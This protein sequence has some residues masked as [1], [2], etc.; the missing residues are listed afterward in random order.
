MPA[1]K[2][3]TAPLVSLAE[4]QAYYGTDTTHTWTFA[5]DTDAVK[6]ALNAPA[7]EIVET[8]R[9]LKNSPDLIFEFVH[10]QIEVEFA[11]GLRK[12]ALGTLIN[13]SGTPFDQNALFV[14][15]VRQAGFEAQYIIGEA[16]F[17]AAEFTRWTGVSDVQAACRLLAAGGIPA[18][19]NGSATWSADC[20]QAGTLASVTMFH[21]WSKVKIEGAWYTFDPSFKEHTSPV[22][23][24]LIAASGIGAGVAAS[25]VAASQ[26]GNQA[27]SNFIRNA[28]T[29]N[30]NS[31]LNSR[32]TQLLSDLTTSQFS[33][34]TDTV[35]GISKIV[36]SYVPVG[37]WRNTNLSGHTA[38][39]GPITGDIP[40]QYRSKLHVTVGNFE[41][42]NNYPSVLDKEFYVDDID[43]RQLGV[44]SSF[45][46]G[47]YPTNGVPVNTPYPPPPLSLR[48]MFD[49]VALLTSGD[50]PLA[51]GGRVTLQASHPYAANSGTYGR[52]SAIYPLASFLTPFTIVS[53]WGH[54]SPGL[55]SKWGRETGLDHELP[56]SAIPY[57]CGGYDSVVGWDQCWD[58]S[59]RPSGDYSNQK[60]T[61]NW[62]AQLS[63]MIALQAQLGGAKADHQ[64]SIGVVSGQGPVR[65]STSPDASVPGARNYFDVPELFTS[66]NVTTAIS[67][68]SKTNDAIRRNAIARS[69]GLAAATLEGSVIEQMQDLPDTASTATRFAWGNRP[70]AEDPC[71]SQIARRFYNFT[72]STVSSRNGL[73]VYEGVPTGCDAFPRIEDPTTHE[74]LA[75]MAINRLDTVIDGYLTDGF[76]VNASAE[77]FL[78]PGARFGVRENYWGNYPSLQRGGALVATQYDATG[79]V[80]QIA[81]A[82][83][84]E[85]GLMKGG[86]GMQPENFSQYDPSKA[87]DVLKDRFVDHSTMLGVD[88]K[89]GDAG[90]TTPTLLSVGGSDAPYG[91]KLVGTFK[92]G[93][94][95]CVDP[96][97][98]PKG[99]GWTH[100]WDIRFNNSGSGLEAMGATSPRAAAG[101]L[102]AF[103]IMQDIYAQTNRTNLEK[104][105]Y[106]AL[107][108]DWWRQQM[109]AN[110]VTITRGF[111]GQQFVR[112][113]DNTWM[114]PVG[115]PAALTQ[116][117]SRT[118]V[119]DW[120]IADPANDAAEHRSTSRRWD[121]TNVSFSLRNAGGDVLNFAS[122]FGGYDTQNQCRTAYYYKPTTWVFPQGPS[123]SFE[124]DGVLGVLKVTSS[125][126]REL[127]FTHD[128]AA[129]AAL[130]SFTTSSGSASARYID[131]ITGSGFRDAAGNSYTIG[132]GP[133]IAER[134]ATQRPVPYSR[135]GKVYEPV[136]STLP[137][138]EFTYD[139]RGLVKE[140][141][142]ANAW[143]LQSH[144]PHKWY[145]AEGARGEHVDPVGGSYTVYFD[146]DGNA[147]R[148]I[149]ELGRETASVY[150]G[151]H[152]V[153][154]RTF[155]EHDTDKFGYD[156]FDNVTSLTK[157]P[158]SCWPNLDNCTGQISISAGY[159]TIWNKLDHIVDALGNR[160]DFTYYDAGVGSSML[161]TVQRPAVDN[162]R[163]IYS[164]E[165]N[166]LGLL[167]KEVDPVGVTTIHGYDSSGNRTSTTV[168]TTAVGSHPAL[169]LT[170]AF[171]YD[172]VG[173]L[174]YVDGPR[175][176]VD[177]T[178]YFTYDA[179]RRRVFEISPDPDDV[180]PHPRP[181]Q[182]TIYDA[183]GRVIEVQRGATSSVSGEGFEMDSKVVTTYDPSGNAIAKKTYDR[184]GVVLDFAQ[185]SYDAD[186]R[187]VCTA[188]RM[189]SGAFASAPDDACSI[190]AGA[191]LE[192]RITRKYYDP[193]GQLLREVR[194]FGSSVQQ[195]YATSTYT[196]DGLLDTV[197]DAD[198]GSH[199][200]KYVYDDFNRLH[201]TSFAFGSSEQRNEQ[202][203]YDA[204]GKVTSRT[205]RAGKTITYTYD[206]LSRLVG[207]S[208]PVDSGVSPAKTVVWNYD[209]AGRIVR[210]SD[211]TG[212]ADSNIIVN[213]FDAAGR[214]VSLTNTIAGFPSSANPA[215]TIGYELDA[216][217][218]RTKLT[219][220]DGPYNVGYAYDALNHMLG[221]CENAAPMISQLAAGTSVSCSNGSA[222]L[223][224]FGY[225]NLA[226]VVWRQ[227]PAGESADK[228]AYSWS[229]QDELM[230]LL[231]TI[232]NGNSVE[233]INRY[234][235]AHQ[236]VTATLSNNAYRYMSSCSGVSSYDPVNGLNQY[237]HVTA[238]CGGSAGIDYDPNGNLTTDQSSHY[239]YDPENQLVRA[240]TASMTASYAYD[241]S[242]RR[243]KKVV[244]GGVYSGT[245]Y[246]LNSGDDEIAEYNGSG[247]LLSRYV[248]G[249]SVDQPLAMVTAAGVKS[250][251]H[252]DK[253]GSVIAMTS[254]S[255]APTE[256]PY[257]YDAYGNCR[258]G[259]AACTGGV[260]YK[261]TGRRYDPET[262]LYYYRARYY[263]AGIGRFLQTDPIG[264]KDDLNLYAYVGNDPTD[265]TDPSGLSCEGNSPG[266]YSC[267]FDH[268]Q[269][270]YN[271]DGTPNLL[272]RDQLS[273]SELKA[274]ERYEASYT[275]AVNRL[276]SNPNQKVQVA[277]PG[278]DGGKFTVTAGQVASALISRSFVRDYT[279]GHGNAGANTMHG[280]TRVFD[281]GINVRD[282]FS[283]MMG[284]VHE[285]IHSSPQEALGLRDQNML[286]YKELNDA[287]QKPY[288]GAASGLLDGE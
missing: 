113:A 7:P 247:V 18:T 177:D 200:T 19:F 154:S 95:A 109:V 68:T 46:K 170:S 227:Y 230:T 241:P 274:V 29:E 133:D 205:T 171:G 55:A 126:G 251:F 254:T 83:V 27:G 134:S 239:Q 144:G 179:V 267:H 191:T 12:G 54:I 45:E 219:W 209:L 250:F 261:F 22:A 65:M 212:G 255:G 44:R 98:G 76:D 85:S 172:T 33:Q 167:A 229:P 52:Q 271:K 34:D 21:I 211:A 147:V 111:S 3:M 31:Y 245:T 114:P 56:N 253:L 262:G 243:T 53:A 1:M 105:V 30:L 140:A 220:P 84:G 8:A 64:H 273:K 282:N 198:G 182:K 142:D 60:M 42:L 287:H 90:Y 223:A 202:L 231:H 128:V 107:A 138:L 66:L 99:G 132:G 213:E 37:G 266:H 78:G 94:K 62:L 264:T 24:N 115:S 257:A 283:R 103:L 50:V 288:N 118:K 207:K 222:P 67:I 72:G 70:D 135:I 51:P 20:S 39:G 6:A 26:S 272:R 131:T 14:A 216:A 232:S 4:A 63:K 279:Q 16:Q 174:V 89:T 40:N 240:T 268:F 150:D 124:Y 79:N 186:N 224:S 192:D 252:Q 9:A 141:K 81:H 136:S 234:S 153:V 244:A 281:R 176:D 96:C 148:H 236:I 129:G 249:M 237:T 38:L 256:G 278:A 178:S 61:A 35:V 122:T 210:S 215:K 188:I 10:N 285:G 71:A 217:G 47:G 173:N 197:T 25:Q 159:N 225:D 151:R 49:D 169:N 201:V 100:N 208:V 166:P 86:G 162:S 163:P 158:K 74:V 11:F 226:R 80:L 106:A 108:A 263:S 41:G 194:G 270:G 235:P 246:F 82:I 13:K 101:T 265:K 102:V 238:A 155:P 97:L 48:L 260:P 57:A 77:A 17:T 73:Y 36:P 127:A 130:P 214:L 280:L 180:G 2:I 156:N 88:L 189:N 195:T 185:M 206:A 275:Q 286:G 190:T 165:Y 119:R 93:L 120:C 187:V 277:V 233:F 149:D 32:A 87:A 116:M 199:I 221:A 259:G 23:R 203:D 248:P 15:L 75:A 218:N 91:L 145:I 139:S 146:T 184:A 110:V 123:L 137:V 258:V 125:I 161:H 117:G 69:V 183:R 228:V 284:I 43:G 168:G 193:A 276:T 181:A 242:G 175:T 164:F 204:N 112:L 92:A 160:T 157:Y 196:P 104:D 59:Q 28:N 152:R 269:N 121:H 143:Q 58:T 5:N